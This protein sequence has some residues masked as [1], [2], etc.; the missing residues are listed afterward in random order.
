[1]AIPSMPTTET[2]ALAQAKE[3]NADA[4]SAA[5]VAQDVHEPGLITA[6]QTSVLYSWKGFPRYNLDNLVGRKGLKVYADMMHD[7]QVKAV[8]NFRRDAVTA[9]NWSLKFDAD[10]ALPEEEQGRRVALMTRLL[11]EMD[12]GITAGLNSI[13][14]A[15][16]FGYSVTEKV[17]DY[18]KIDGLN[19]YYVCELQSKPLDSFWFETDAYGRITRFYQLLGGLK[20]DLE[21]GKFIYYVHNP[22]EDNIFGRSELRAAYRSWYAK[23]VIIRFWNLWMERMAGGFLKVTRDAAAQTVVPG[24]PEYAALQR[25]LSSITT[26]TSM[27]LPAGFDAALISPG[28]TDQYQAALSWHDRAIAKSQLVPNLLG[29]SDQ[30]AHGALAQSTTQLEAFA[31]TLANISKRLADCVNDQLLYELCEQA[32]ADGDYPYFAFSAVTDAQ[33]QWIISTWQGLLGAKGVHATIADEVHIRRIL[34]FPTISPEELAAA[35][36]QAKQ[37]AID[38]AQ[39]NRPTPASGSGGAFARNTRRAGPRIATDAQFDRAIARVDFAIIDQSMRKLEYERTRQLARVVAK[40]LSRVISDARLKE[41][42]T[43]DIAHIGSIGI[44]GAD[45]SKFKQVCRDALQAAWTIGRDEAQRELAKARN[46]PMRRAFANSLDE[47]IKLL[48]ANSFRMAGDLTDTA[49]RIISNELIQA[50]KGN[51]S[52]GEARDAIIESFVKRGLTDVDSMSEYLSSDERAVLESLGAAGYKGG[53]S[54]YLDTMIRTTT[55]DAMNQ[56]RLESFRDP[57]LGEFVQALEYSAI[58]DDHTTEICAELNGDTWSVD[59]PL[60]NTYTPP[61]HFNCRS[62]VVPVTTL[63]GWDGEEDPAPDVQPQEGFK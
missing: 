20:N 48:D 49:R 19:Y 12:G 15:L 4:V 63:D 25:A 11:N 41:L 26:T 61:N 34:D 54:A 60:W 9:R 36:A 45:V 35:D 44:D 16:Q 3:A 6:Y 8:M 37:N 42:L 7:E 47:A 10:S 13:L 14:R 30:G 40:A 59:N 28:N 56:A 62:V 24:T 21:L 2:Q 29:V 39:A 33:L 1:M 43:V 50:A 17:Y 52:V 31:W 32:F 18:C 57:D 55:F 51:K 22:E 38:I 46:K 5:V 58:L 53:D 23:D 27:L